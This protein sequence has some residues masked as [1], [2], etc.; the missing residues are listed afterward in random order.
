MKT[1]ELTE[2]ECNLLY[3]VINTIQSSVL[4][5]T[6]EQDFQIFSNKD[7]NENLKFKEFSHEWIMETAQELDTLQAIKRKIRQ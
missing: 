6:A 1:I 7:F 4:R 2:S 5:R 3:T